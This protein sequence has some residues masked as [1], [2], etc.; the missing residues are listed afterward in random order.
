MDLLF[1]LAHWHA[2]AK[3][4][5]HT[6]LSLDLLD[7]ITI[8]L[9]Q[10]LRD[11]QEKTCSAFNT[12][13]LQRE[14]AARERRTGKKAAANKIAAENTDAAIGSNTIVVSTS[15]PSSVEPN[16]PVSPSIPITK[17]QASKPLT[18]KA[19]GRRHKVLNLNTYKDHSLGDYV[20]T[21]RRN[22]TSDSY[23]TEPVNRHVFGFHFRYLL[24]YQMELEHR[25]PKSRYL[26]TSRKNF[27]KQLTQIERRQ[28]RIRRIRQKFNDNGKART[29]FKHEKGPESSACDY[30]IGKTQN[31]PLN[32]D[33]L[34]RESRDDPAAKV[35]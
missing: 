9:G 1:T 2:V 16:V 28:A 12:Q 21:I 18:T 14:A 8:Q 25:S 30:H 29:V 19:V 24:E 34:A 23:S 20:E 26:R 35:R 10:S 5:Q 7:S 11:F 31:H 27:E 6:D 15:P 3:L 33:L 13:E 4:R 22:G 17:K 32:L